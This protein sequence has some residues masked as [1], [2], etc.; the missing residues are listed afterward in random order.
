M[1][2]APRA[3]V[4]LRSQDEPARG[5]LRGLPQTGDSGDVGDVARA[6]DRAGGDVEVI[7]SVIGRDEQRR[8]QDDTEGGG[9]AEGWL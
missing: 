4:I 5:V 8:H 2:I 7:P 6:T 9:D 1:C 3:S